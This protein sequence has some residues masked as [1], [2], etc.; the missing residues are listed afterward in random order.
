MNEFLDEYEILGGKMKPRLEGDTNI[1]KLDT[2]RKALGPVKIHDYDERD[3]GDISIPVDV[4][5]VKDTWDC[6]TI[7]TTYSNLE[8]HPRL[9]RVREAK[10]VQ[11]IKLDPKTGLPTPINLAP[12]KKMEDLSEDDGDDRIVKVTITRLKG[13]SKEEKKA[14][15]NAVK[16]E[17]RGRRV[18]KKAT[19][20][21]FTTELK[22]QQ[23]S[24]AQKESS[25]MKKL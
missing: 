13:E 10:A 6:E 18:E 12:R 16:E 4:D 14:R 1:E 11:K 2:I 8:N 24:A 19:R 23:N 17:R 22:K 25:R 5:D 20:T 3:D 9:I 21:E 15:K 7:L